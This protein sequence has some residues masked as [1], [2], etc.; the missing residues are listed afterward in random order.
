MSRFRKKNYYKTNPTPTILIT[1]LLWYNYL[2]FTKTMK[3]TN[4]LLTLFSLLPL[5]SCN[6]KEN[7]GL[8]SIENSNV[9]TTSTLVL[10]TKERIALNLMQNRTSKVTEKEAYERA[11]SFIT[12]VTEYS[13]N[14]SLVLRSIGNCIP[15][16]AKTSSS[17]KSANTIDNLSIF[18]N[19]KR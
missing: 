7:I 10:S 12:D 11:E 14:K 4:Y 17:L 19:I 5:F 9:D 3:G 8:E 16:R 18:T 6:E 1:L 2:L 13:T 15:L